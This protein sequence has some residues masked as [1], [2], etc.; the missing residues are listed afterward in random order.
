MVDAL[1][2]QVFHGA[3]RRSDEAVAGGELVFVSSAERPALL[4]RWNDE[5]RLVVTV[6]VGPAT[7]ARLAD[8]IEEAVEGALGAHGAAAPGIGTASDR[9]AQ[10]SDQLFRARRAGKRGIALALGRLRTATGARG[11]L[12]ADD[13]ATLAFLASATRTRPL[14]L[15]LDAEDAATGAFGEPVPLASLVMPAPVAHEVVHDTEEAPPVAISHP[16][17]VIRHT[18]DVMS[19]TA[20]AA[21]AEDD[22][23]W[24]TWLLALTAARGPQPL[25]AFE[26]LFTQ[27]YLPLTAAIARGLTDPRA[28]HATED[29][30]R[31]FARSYADAVPTFALTG[32][33]P[34]MVLDVPDLA[35]RIA[36]LHGARSTQLLCVDS[37]R[38]DLGA[39]VVDALVRTLGPRASLTEEMSLFAALPSTTFRQLECIAR[40][41]DALRERTNPEADD[42]AA[43]G[44]G[45]EILRRMRVGSRDLYKLDLVEAR[46]RAFDCGG[47]G[48]PATLDAFPEIAASVAEVIGKHA[49]SLAA[50]T[51]LFVFGDHGFA[52]EPSGAVRQGGSS[53]EEVLV[54]A[55]AFLVGAVH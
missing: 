17:D 48:A 41:P 8:A 22:D 26:K 40:G 23:S 2:T 51:L 12:E 54:P 24:R 42:T 34:R 37:M 45:A 9:E 27:S 46:L 35:A 36:R 55:Y 43:R 52:V 4:Q 53:P 16:A 49:A 50:R 47:E 18:A 11:A 7:R 19:H 5:A 13:S 29:F 10:L 39:L 6:D 31:T 14:G 1:D 33:R 32:K 3:T 21:I 38:W 44:R 25:S 28:R 15:L 20:G 30:R